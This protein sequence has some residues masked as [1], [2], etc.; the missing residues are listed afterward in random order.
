MLLARV[1]P[2]AAL[3]VLATSSVA[4]AQVTN[5]GAAAP[6]GPTPPPTTSKGPAGTG[7]TPPTGATP[8]DTPATAAAPPGAKVDPTTAGTT[9]TTDV[10]AASTTA[11]AQPLT[12]DIV[13]LAAVKTSKYAAVD[14]AKLK[15]AASQVD[16][17]WDQYWPRLSFSAR[18]TR[19]SPITP[20]TIGGG[21]GF[22]TVVAPVPPQQPVPPGTP[23]A[24]APPISFPVILD[25]Y[26][27]QASLLIPL[28]DYVFRTWQ[29]HQAALASYEAAKWNAEVTKMDANANAR[30]AFYNYLRA[31]GM[32]I[33]AKS[34]AGLADAHL[35]DMKHRLDAK[36]V[37]IADV[38][39]V[40]ANLA[41]AE[42]AV[43]KT[44]NLVIITDANLR[45]MMHAAGDAEF[46]L[47]ED[48]EAELSKADVELPKLKATAFSKRPELKAVDAQIAAVENNANVVGAGM[49]PRLDAIGNVTYA[50]P[51]QRFFPISP[52]WR[53]TWDVSLQLSWS[54]NDA[55]IASDNKKVVSGQ[56]AVLKATRE[57]VADGLVLDVTTAYTKVREAE[58]SIATTK[59]E[60]RAAEEAYRVRKEQFTLGATTSALLIE[61]EA[62]LTRARLN[63][64]N[65]RVDLRIARVQLKK[66]IGE[67]Q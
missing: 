8:V 16:A 47:G 18:Y 62:D 50:N 31:R 57:Q 1:A 39:R 56:I 46:S 60:L 35:K 66:A 29:N 30:V 26:Q 52:V 67:L 21:S 65:A 44:E 4:S 24:T 10:V 3:F 7:T 55:L 15:S 9:T 36:V 17:A 6:A 37:T 40:E 61:S 34:A 20:P 43:I 58:A 53:A 13:A 5:P 27:L 45:V 49:W 23:L 25:Q 12:A 11:T 14:V 33:V 64:L 22:S 59:V 28:S 19:L 51:N 63:H 48:L 32:V 41:A 2:L 54:P 42:L 38:A